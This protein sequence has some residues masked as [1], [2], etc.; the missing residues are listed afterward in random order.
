[1]ITDTMPERFSEMRKKGVV[2]PQCGC[3]SLPVVYTR[4]FGRITRRVRQ[5]RVCSTRIKCDEIMV[6][7]VK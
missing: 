5:C 2:C 4:R 3:P 1:M 7:E 6:E